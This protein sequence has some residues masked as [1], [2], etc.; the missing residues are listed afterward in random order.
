VADYVRA[1]A[2]SRGGARYCSVLMLPAL[3]ER[4]DSYEQQRRQRMTLSLRAPMVG[5][6]RKTK[7]CPKDSIVSLYFTGCRSLAARSPILRPYAVP[8][9]VALRKWNPTNTRDTAFSSAA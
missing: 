7:P 5:N 2:I 6:R 3:K 4:R 8:S 9:T 1:P